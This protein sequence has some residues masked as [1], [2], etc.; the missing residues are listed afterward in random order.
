MVTISLEKTFRVRNHLPFHIDFSLEFDGN[1][2]IAITGPSGVGKTSI[3]RM[4]A[5]LLIP[6]HGKIQIHSNV[7]Y[8][9][10]NKINRSVQQRNLGYVFQEYALFPHM[11]VKQNIEFAEKNGHKLVEEYMDITGLMPYKNHRPFA[12][13]GGQQQRVALARALVSNP[14]ILLL[15]EPLSALDT[16]NRMKMQNMLKEI[17][18]RLNIPVLLVS[19]DKSDIEKLADRIVAVEKGKLNKE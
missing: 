15:D 17:F 2:V 3:L 11:T 18:N 8:D 9:S 6:D 5:G 13:S 10:E 16:G 19:H 1:S 14:D 7:W 12:L 4:V